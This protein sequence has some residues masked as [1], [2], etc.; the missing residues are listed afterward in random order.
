VERFVRTSVEDLEL[1]LAVDGCNFEEANYPPPCEPAVG[2]LRIRPLELGGVKVE[3]DRRRE[4]ATDDFRL[5]VLFHGG[6]CVFANAE[7]V[8][9]FFRGP[10][11]HA[12]GIAAEPLPASRPTDELIDDLRPAPPPAP[13]EPEPAKAAPPAGHSSSPARKSRS[14]RSVQSAPRARDLAD[15]LALEIH[16]QD[17]ALSRL[18]AAISTHLA[19]PA[20]A[21]PA[22]ILLLGPTGTGK[23]SSVQAL[24]RA[25]HDLGRSG[26]HVF[27]VDCNEVVSGSDTR[28]FLGAPPSY[29]GYVEEPPLFAALRTPGCIVL[30]DEVEKAAEELQWILLGLLDEGRIGAPDG[31]TV[32]APATVVT[33]TSNAG[34]EDLAY[35]VR[36]LPAGGRDEQAACR[37]HLLELDWPAELVGRIGTFAVFDALDERSLHEVAESAIHGLAAEFGLRLEKLP[38]VLADVVRDLADARDIGARALDYAARDLLTPAFS[39]A[40]REGVSGLVELDPGPPP[41]VVVA[42][43]VA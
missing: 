15:R 31:T 35:R 12:F 40:A 25:L 14:S 26:T 10:V 33:M 43:R 23:T 4:L 21:R 9:A 22:S 34:A 5:A 39:D 3:V 19:K 42:D 20:P 7:D 18:A 30:L 6:S 32:D 1:L 28:R 27:R 17:G 11:A 38:P 24:P 36:D 2:R 29:I 37:E 16:G 8:A 41:R 13:A